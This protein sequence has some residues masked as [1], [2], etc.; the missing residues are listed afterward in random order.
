MAIFISAFRP[1][2]RDPSL[3]VDITEEPSTY[4][5][6]SVAEDLDR[7]QWF[8]P[9]VVDTRIEIPTVH[10]YGEKD[11]F[12]NQAL[13]TVK[14]SGKGLASVVVHQGGHEI[15]MRPDVCKSIRD[16]IVAAVERSGTLQ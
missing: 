16:A 4:P 12:L 11:E 13:E 2:S 7:C 1:F 3:G 15:P 8:D 9:A 10:V 14:L 6:A 5:P